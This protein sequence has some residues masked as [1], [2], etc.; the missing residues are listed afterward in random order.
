MKC[1]LKIYKEKE[2]V[3]TLIYDKDK[4]VFE[5]FYN[6]TIGKERIGYKT[7]YELGYNGN[8]K[9]TQKCPSHMC[10][11]VIMYTYV[12]EFEDMIF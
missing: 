4:D 3:N 10:D 11:G 7:K 5:Q 12:Y 9:A 6:L 2:L 8:I 1:T